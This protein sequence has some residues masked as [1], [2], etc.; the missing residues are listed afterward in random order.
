[1]HA[2][3]TVDPYRVIGRVDPLIYGQFLSRR[4]GVADGALYNPAHPDADET[5]LRRAVVTA[6]EESAPTI[7]RW[8]GGCT[9]TSYDWRDGIGPRD[10]RPRT[11]DA[12]FGYDVGNGF[13]TV[14][15]AAFCRRIG[16]APHLNLNTGTGNLKDALEWIEYTNFTTNSKWANLRRTH[17][18]DEPFGVRYWQIGNENYGPWEIGQQS[19]REYAVMARE[20]AKAIKKLDPALQVLA[21]GGSEAR[22]GS[23]AWDVAV[24]E[25]AWGH[26]D[27][28]TA[29]RYWNFNSGEGRDNYDAIAGAGYIEEQTISA[30]GGLIALIA[31]EK[32]S[33]RRPRLAFTEWNA[34]DQRQ[35]EMSATWRPTDTQY[36][37]VDALA[38]AGFLNALQRQC[39]IVGLATVA[40]SI[41]VV[42]LLLVTPEHI[43]RETV[44]WA[45]LMQRHHSGPEAVD[46]R[47]ECGGYSTECEGRTIAGIP[48]LDVSATR[49]EANKR[50]FISIVN[51]HRTEEAVTRIRLRD[52]LSAGE[53][54]L[55]QLGHDN[56]LARNTL[57]APNRIVPIQSVL[58]R[59]GAESE[60]ALP[61]HSYS[62]LEMSLGG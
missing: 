41:N 1:M 14:E 9:G 44:Y 58:D 57:D 38:A 45:C 26:I 51:R 4:R 39:N 42:G 31:R 52:A 3:V 43:V 7:I 36:R 24:L 18:H 11:I 21:V 30:L 60:V 46:T 32:R 48:Y 50:L 55:Y 35:Q 28:L 59:V 54:M 37:L 27:Y 47:V 12:H 25:E 62:I 17:G 22:S 53:M 56:P 13:G 61:P 23:P 49:D 40:Q 5:G 16:A 10:A 34:R 33:V 15:F 8:P 19:P 29:H 2:T 20:W 6:I